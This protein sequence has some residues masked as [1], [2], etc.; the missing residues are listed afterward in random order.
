MFTQADY[1]KVLTLMMYE[2]SF[3]LDHVS[4]IADDKALKILLDIKEYFEA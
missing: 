3:R 2:D 1:F 4:H